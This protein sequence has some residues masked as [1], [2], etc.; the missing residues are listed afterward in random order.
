MEEN[1]KKS[2]ASAY[3]GFFL[4]SLSYNAIAPILFLLVFNMTMTDE[5]MI[6]LMITPPSY[7]IL[8][9]IISTIANFHLVE[10]RHLV[11]H[12]WIATG[13]YLL[14]L[15]LPLGLAVIL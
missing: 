3:F 4:G 8:M 11:K 12:Y 13:I 10:N 14:I 6:W 1:K 9:I 5:A 2:A 7:A 15:I